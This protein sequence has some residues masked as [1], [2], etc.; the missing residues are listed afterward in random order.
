[1]RTLGALV[2]S[3]LLA[4]ASLAACVGDDPAPAP[5]APSADGGGG[6]GGACTDVQKA[7]N[8]SC[9][10]KDDPNAG[11]AAPDCTP[12]APATNAAPACK[13][14]ACSFACND[15][16]SDCDGDPATGCESK[17]SG[18][19]ANC[20]G[21]G[22]ACGSANTASPATCEAGAC[23]FACKAGFAHCGASPASGGC[24]TDLQTN[25]ESCGACG[26][27]C[28][29]GQCVGG[30]CQ[31]F[32]LAS[33]SRPNGVAVDATNVYFTFP[34]VP[35]IQ[36]V[37]RDGTCTP[38]SPCPKDFAGA[39]LD[40]PL[41]QIRG[42]S[43]IVSDG[44]SVWWTNQANGTLGR[45]AAGGGAITNWGPA[46]STEP[47]YL[48]LAGGKIWWTNAF[49]SAEPTFHVYRSDLDGSNVTGV[50][51]YTNPATSF[52][53]DGGITADASHV[54]W[55]SEKSGVY[56]AA[57][58]DAPCVEGSTCKPV[59]TTGG[60]SAP[61]GVAVD[62]TF[63]YWTE[64]ASGTIRRA[65]KAGTGASVQVATGQDMPKAIAA[66]GGFVYWG[67]VGTTNATAGTIRRAPQVGA[68]CDGAAC[69]LVATA[70]APTAI[71]AGDDG[72]Y[73]T[74][75]VAAGGV[76]RLAK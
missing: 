47:G 65:P 26:H 62:D 45:R 58:A 35:A 72:L 32:Q 31:P 19:P 22:T 61:Y 74:D 67:N 20:G 24:E 10:S 69:E 9:F 42:P 63:V 8:G 14:G 66:M 48:A 33:A 3:S 44:T 49:A 4:F 17:T 28:L 52:F 18:D 38:A 30:K 5:V 37:G 43:A 21:C 76:Y 71:V 51:Q 73:W 12:C 1:M 27:S 57:F 75:D 34:S 59:Y 41:T 11:C 70:A 23:V 60:A 40:D 15:G 36:S 46:R 50:A 53:G 16:F 68:V 25:A 29:G 2:A 39:A 54:Y 6:G 7:C 55:A 64:P 56:M 13:A